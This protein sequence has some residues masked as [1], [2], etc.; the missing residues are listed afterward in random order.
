MAKSTPH[1]PLP[2]SREQVGTD[3][4]EKGTRGVA[5]RVIEFV[6][7]TRGPRSTFLA[8]VSRIADKLA[9][10][11][12]VA[13]EVHAFAQE[14]DGLNSS[15]FDRLQDLAWEDCVDALEVEK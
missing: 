13:A 3:I 12:G 8:V 2:L 11:P 15:A 5:S 1:I 6:L 10:V 14:V 4:E 9:F 7:A